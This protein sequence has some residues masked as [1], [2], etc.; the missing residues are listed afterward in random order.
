MPRANLYSYLRQPSMPELDPRH[1]AYIANAAPFAQP[2]LEHLRAVVHEAYPAIE[3]TIKW[4]MP[5]Y[6]VNGGIVC[7]M[8]AFKQHC[9]FGLWRAGELLG[10]DAPAGA[11]ES[12]G[13]GNY[14]KIRSIDDLPPRDQLLDTVSRIAVARAATAQQSS[15]PT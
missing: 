12:S 2:I 7:H 14:G 4:G 9:A 11:E 1:D 8:A 5:M 10:D 13:M 15:K 6:T 3:E